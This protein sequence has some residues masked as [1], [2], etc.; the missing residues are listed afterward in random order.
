MKGQ[1]LEIRQ[2][3]EVL[4]K[5]GW[6]YMGFDKSEIAEC[7]IKKRQ[8]FRYL[9]HINCDNISFD[10]IRTDTNKIP[11]EQVPFRFF[12]ELEEFYK[13]FNY[14]KRTRK[15]LPSDLAKNQKDLDD[16]FKWEFGY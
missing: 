15:G 10:C 7:F 6:I 3:I 8:P 12:Y 11:F 1:E 4:D 5:K 14:M 2:I 13:I 16:Y 9:I